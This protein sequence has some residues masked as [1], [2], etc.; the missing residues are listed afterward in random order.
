MLRSE[1]EHRRQYAAAFLIGFQKLQLTEQEVILLHGPIPLA[2]QLGV[3]KCEGAVGVQMRANNGC[4]SRTE[5][6][7]LLEDLHRML[8]TGSHVMGDSQ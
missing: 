6:A 4:K 7:G 5:H 8:C 2:T 1:R 3:H